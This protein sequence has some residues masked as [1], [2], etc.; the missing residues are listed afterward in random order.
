[1][2]IVLVVL[3]LMGGFA[4]GTNN[5]ENKGEDTPPETSATV[6]GNVQGSHPVIP[7]VYLIDPTQCR[8]NRGVIYR[9]LTLPY[10]GQ[11]SQRVSPSSNCDGESIDD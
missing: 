2:E 3:L 5:A 8:S 11:V 7:V 4:L 6:A 10:H 1:M 9:D